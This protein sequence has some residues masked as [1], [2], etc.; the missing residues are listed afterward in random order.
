MKGPS[1]KFTVNGI[2]Y[3]KFKATEEEIKL[4]QDNAI[5]NITIVG[6]C[7]IN[8]WGGVERPQIIVVDYEVNKAIKYYI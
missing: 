4:F 1:L 2:E 6:E 7:D 3:I 8:T 5:V